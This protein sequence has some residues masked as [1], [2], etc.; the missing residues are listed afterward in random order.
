MTDGIFEVAKA[1][2]LCQPQAVLIVNGAI[3]DQ[4][5]NPEFWALINHEDRIHHSYEWAAQIPGLIGT[6]C[7]NGDCDGS[8]LKQPNRRLLGGCYLFDCSASVDDFIASDLWKYCVEG[9]PW[10]TLSL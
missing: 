4:T 5:N 9:T 2:E 8:M 3:D 7:L 1:K 10:N 6:L